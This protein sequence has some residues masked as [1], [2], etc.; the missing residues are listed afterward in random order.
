MGNKANRCRR[1][2]VRYSNVDVGN[3]FPIYCI[4]RL[5]HSSMKLTFIFGLLYSLLKAQPGVQIGGQRGR[6]WFLRLLEK[7]KRVIG[8]NNGKLAH[9]KGLIN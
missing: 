1:F 6:I 7:Y 9:L 3:D 2:S 4:V 5:F 8:Q